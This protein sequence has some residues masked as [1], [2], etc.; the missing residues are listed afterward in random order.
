MDLPGRHF[1]ED[2]LRLFRH[3]LTISYFSFS[4]QFY[5]QTDGVAVGSPLCPAIANFYMDFEER[6]LDLAPHKPLCWFR[7]VDDTFVI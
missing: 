7:Y 3:V 4:G 5:E 2:V 6:A 1:A